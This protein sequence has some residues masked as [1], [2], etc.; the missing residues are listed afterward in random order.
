[1]RDKIAREKTARTPEHIVEALDA[2]RRNDPQTY[3]AV[4]SRLR[5]YLD[6]QPPDQPLESAQGIL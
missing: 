1:M 6:A 3:G 5:T 4:A 2:L